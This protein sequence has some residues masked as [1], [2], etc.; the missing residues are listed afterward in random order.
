MGGLCYTESFLYLPFI[1][2]SKWSPYGKEQPSYSKTGWRFCHAVGLLF[3]SD[4]GGTEG[5]RDA[6]KKN[7]IEAF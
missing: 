4:A 1:Q 6:M 2:P 3:A 5:V 7:I